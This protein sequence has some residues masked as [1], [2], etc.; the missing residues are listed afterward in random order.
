MHACIELQLHVRAV[1]CAAHT[2]THTHPPARIRTLTSQVSCDG[3]EPSQYDGYQVALWRA[4][5][6]DLALNDSDWA[7]SCLDWTAMIDDL[8]NPNGSC[9][10]APAG[11]V[12]GGA[13]ASAVGE[14]CLCCERSK[15]R[16]AQRRR[17]RSSCT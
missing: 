2:H 17:Q 5:A 3:L 12:R 4:I 15:T 11:A 14:A 6:A 13:A 7:F 8:A 10:F 16:M 9:S 1:L